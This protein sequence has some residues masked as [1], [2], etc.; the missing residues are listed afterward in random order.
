LRTSVSF[1]MNVLPRDSVEQF[2]K[3]EVLVPHWFDNDPARLLTQLDGIFHTNSNH[4]DTA[5]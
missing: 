4:P 1:A 3:V 5:G 2:R